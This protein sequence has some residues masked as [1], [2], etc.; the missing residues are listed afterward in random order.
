VIPSDGHE[1]IRDDIGAAERL[2]TGEAQQ[3]S[4]IALE[5]LAQERTADLEAQREWL[6]VTLNSIGDA[7]IATDTEG[8]VTFLNP[9][10]ETLTGWRQTEAL[11][12]DIQVVFVIINEDT[13]ESV[14]SPVER[15]LR[16]GITVGLANPTLLVS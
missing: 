3:M 10:A 12:K 5:T 9:V 11:G 16:E 4:N 13:G 1:S 7:V 15:A 8:R 6:R 14:E 2:N